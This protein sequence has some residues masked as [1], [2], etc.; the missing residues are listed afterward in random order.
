MPIDTRTLRPG[1][2]RIVCSQE[3]LCRLINEEL[4][5]FAACRD[6]R[7]VALRKLPEAR[8]DG[9]NWDAHAL[10]A[11]HQFAGACLPVFART[12]IEFQAQYNLA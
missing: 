3:D 5:R 10:G 9:C 4:A 1:G 8:Q 2:V 6:C 7:V 11:R 12:I